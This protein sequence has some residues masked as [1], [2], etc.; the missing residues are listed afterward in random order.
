LATIFCG[1]QTNN[2]EAIVIALEGETFP[3][4]A[5]VVRHAAT[6]AATIARLK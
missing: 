4:V 1:V 6:P 5:A 2:L 3:V